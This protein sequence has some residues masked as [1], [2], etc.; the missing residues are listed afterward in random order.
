MTKAKLKLE[1]TVN[2]SFSK[3]KATLHSLA[4]KYLLQLADVVGKAVSLQS[5][6]TECPPSG[7]PNLFVEGIRDE[8][9]AK[10]IA[11]FESRVSGT[12]VF[13]ILIA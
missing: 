1:A 2:A 11:K 13:R 7:I 8:M 12:R 3:L 6:K 10:A 9:V 4:Q 5:T